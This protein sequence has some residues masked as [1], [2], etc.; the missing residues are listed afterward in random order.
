MLPNISAI[1]LRLYGIYCSKQAFD[2]NSVVIIA[3]FFYGTVTLDLDSSQSRRNFLSC[4][5][6]L[7]DIRLEDAKC[8]KSLKTFKNT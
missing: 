1:Y 8:N 3:V 7:A 5:V 2:D 6:V 4:M